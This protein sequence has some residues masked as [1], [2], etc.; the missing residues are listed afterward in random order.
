[1]AYRLCGSQKWNFSVWYFIFVDRIRY[2]ELEVWCF[3]SGPD[4]TRNWRPKSSD[5][6]HH[7]SSGS[8]LPHVALAMRNNQDIPRHNMVYG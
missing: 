7:P 1:M 5:T 2:E 4:M 6:Y 8:R 3:G